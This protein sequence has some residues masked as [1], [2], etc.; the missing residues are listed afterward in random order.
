MSPVGIGFEVTVYQF[1]FGGGMKLVAPP[2][3]ELGLNEL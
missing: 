3:F 2:R 1:L